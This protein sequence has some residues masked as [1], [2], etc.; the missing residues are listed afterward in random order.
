LPKSITHIAVIRLSAM[1]DVAM[2]VPVLRALVK[3]H[4]QVR[5][6]MV[7]RP[8]FKP[9]FNGIPN[10]EFFAVAL[11]DRHKGILGLFRLY[12]DLKTLNVDA[13]ADLHAVLRSKIMRT[14]FSANGKPTAGLDK[15][16]HEKRALTRIKNKVF[17]PLKPTIERYADVFR[18]LGFDVNL[19]NPE[20]PPKPQ[21]TADV[22]A[23]TGLKTGRWIGIAPF[24]AHDPKQYPIALMSRV[25]EGL[26]RDRQHRIFLFGAGSDE[27][28]VLESLRS[29]KENVIVMAGK[30]NF[31]RELELIANLD[32]MLSMDSGNGHMAAMFGVKT[33]TLW[34]ATHPFAGFAPFNQPE[35]NQL[36]SD[37]KQ[38]PLLPTSVYGNKS[39][40]GYQDAMSSISPET[41][42]E[43][44]T[45]LLT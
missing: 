31:E 11:Q 21:L 6:T 9:F 12:S 7:S 26:S 24:A 4:P 10:V 28:Q 15:G 27:I 13:F 37:R 14:I 16:R 5:I 39:L 41:V 33:V 35:A 8:F 30:L 22:L 42:I 19:S 2:T 45:T 32:V 17:K 43:K 25:I 3:Q 1:G 20:Y 40:E 29:D 18:S 38:Y 23:I 44:I 36:V 34:G